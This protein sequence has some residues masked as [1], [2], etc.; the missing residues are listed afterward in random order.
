MDSAFFCVLAETGHVK[1]III[2]GHL[3]HAR[4]HL[5]VSPLLIVFV[6]LCIILFT[7]PDAVNNLVLFVIS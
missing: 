6:Q 5:K 7:K 2:C 1:Q 3:I 4:E